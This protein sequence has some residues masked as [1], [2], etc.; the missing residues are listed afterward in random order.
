[1]GNTYDSVPPLTPNLDHL[2]ANTQMMEEEERKCK[3]EKRKVDSS[4]II[5]RKE[6]GLVRSSGSYPDLL[7]MVT[8]SGSPGSRDHAGMY[9]KV[10]LSRKRSR[11]NSDASTIESHGSTTGGSLVGRGSGEPAEK[12]DGLDSYTRT[13]IDRFNPS[14]RRRAVQITESQCDP[15]CQSSET[16]EIF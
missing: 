7:E 6:K 13:L 14:L 2:Y 5:L 4:K 11:P 1:M 3:E 12:K 16:D 15:V 8:R 9:A 10:D